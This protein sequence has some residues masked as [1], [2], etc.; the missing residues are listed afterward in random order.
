M[1]TFLQT[2]NNGTDVWSEQK[3]LRNVQCAMH[4]VKE[5]IVLGQVPHFA[6]TVLHTKYTLLFLLC[7]ILHWYSLSITW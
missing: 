5:I 6:S 1:V 4:H 2:Y 7:I 3:L